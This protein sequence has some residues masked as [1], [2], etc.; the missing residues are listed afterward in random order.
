M[1][2]TENLPRDT[3]VYLLRKHST[4]TLAGVGLYLNIKNY[5][6]VSSIVERVKIRKSKDKV[7]ARQLI[8]LEEVL[9]K[10]SKGDLTP[11]LYGRYR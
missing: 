8:K 2:G 4:E 7:F 5:S 1:R 3:A 6:T 10:R 9:K 11:S